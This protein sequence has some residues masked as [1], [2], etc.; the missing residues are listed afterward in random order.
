MT[1]TNSPR[2]SERGSAAVKFTIIIVVLFLAANAGF[3]YVPIAYAG[4]NFKQDMDIAVVNGL[5]VAGRFNPMDI[6]KQ[7]LQ[8]SISDNGLPND[9]LVE[10]KQNGNIYQAHA[11]YTQPVHILPFGIYTYN[12]HFDYTAVPKGYL[13]K[14]H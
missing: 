8:R 12:Y 10:V 2:A 6:I 5:A 3:N 1:Q 13:L 7:R 4:E 9:T 14:D 11:V